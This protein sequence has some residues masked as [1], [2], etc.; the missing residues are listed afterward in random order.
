MRFLDADF[1]QGFI[2]MANDGWELGWHERNGG[3][4][5]YRLKPEEVELVKENFDIKEWQPPEAE[6]PSATPDPAPETDFAD[7]AA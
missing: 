4:L 6:H 5:S 3:N 7:N 1:V 2:R